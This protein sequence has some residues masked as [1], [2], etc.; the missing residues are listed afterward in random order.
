M[1]TIVKTNKD[2]FLIGNGGNIKEKFRLKHPFELEKTSEGIK[3]TPYDIE[4]ID[5]II[6]YI[7]YFA[8]EIEYS[9]KPQK[10]LEEFYNTSVKKYI[11]EFNKVQEEE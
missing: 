4:M 11:E 6:P 2:K 5:T 9:V 10:G 1:I 7:D 3:L 8:D